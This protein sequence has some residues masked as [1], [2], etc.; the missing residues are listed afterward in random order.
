[1]LNIKGQ[2]DF[3]TANFSQ[4]IVERALATGRFDRHLDALR[5]IYEKKMLTLHETLDLTL[6]SLGWKWERSSGGLY[7]WLQSPNRLRTDVDS[8]F[9]GA[10]IGNGVFYVPGDLCY[11]GN[12]IK[13]QV[14]LSYGALSTVEIEEA[15]KR[16]TRAAI[17]MTNAATA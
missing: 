5:A 17:S 9:H 12:E 1:M 10:C 11:A 13:D 14:R 4:A 8:E 7:L 16:F 15:A 2:Q 3:G 6:K